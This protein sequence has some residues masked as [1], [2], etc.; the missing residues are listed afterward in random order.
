M[1]NIQITR[2]TNLNLWEIVPSEGAS[3]LVNY[4]YEMRLHKSQLEAS[5]EALSIVVSSLLLGSFESLS[6]VSK[7][8]EDYIRIKWCENLTSSKVTTPTAIYEFLDSYAT[9]GPVH[10]EEANEVKEFLLAE[11]ALPF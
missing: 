3:S 1:R 8:N 2:K 10:K 9:I 5:N 6:V 7:D 11:S 4:Y